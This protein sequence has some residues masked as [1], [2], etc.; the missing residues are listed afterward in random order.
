MITGQ[1][2]RSSSFIHGVTPDSGF[3]HTA[4]V[5]GAMPDS[6]GRIPKAVPHTVGFRFTQTDGLLR[7]RHSTNGVSLAACDALT[8]RAASE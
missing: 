2:S 5:T 1:R 8:E 4:S 7:G 3:L 6:T